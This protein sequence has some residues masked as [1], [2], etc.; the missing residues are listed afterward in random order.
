METIDMALEPK[1]DQLN[2]DDLIAGPATFTIEKVSRGSVEQPVDIHLTER[3][4]RPWRPS[5]SMRRVLVNAWGPDT[6]LYAG[7]RVTLY[8]DP[9]VR[10]GKD[11]V[12][13][14]KVSHLSHI[15]KRTTVSL[16]V[17][18]GKRAPHSVDP[19]PVATP[20]AAAEPTPDDVA[21]CTD[22][23]SLGKMWRESG[24]TMRRVIET[25][26]AELDTETEPES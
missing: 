5:K 22:R 25:R 19:L 16:T 20:N 21:G 1:S 3:P 4:G 17:T 13:G 26:V 18:R 14:V 24:P 7:H 23:E 8:R 6:S 10:F 9:S 12:G 11:E 2:A 15:T